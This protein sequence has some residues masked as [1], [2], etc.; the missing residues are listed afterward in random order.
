[1]TGPNCIG[2]D[3]CPAGWVAATPDGVFLRPRLYDLL[4][5]LGV[6]AERD[7]VAIDMPIG[8]AAAGKRAC[9][10]EARRLL[11]AARGNSVF[12][13]ATRGAVYAT[14][15]GLALR[16]AHARASRINIDNDAGGVSAQAFNLFG[17]IREVDALL[18]DQPALRT[19][20]HEVH[21]ELAFACWNAD[22]GG[23]LRPMP[24][25][26]KSGLGAYDR[27]QR[28]F[29][30]YSRAHF[31]HFRQKHRVGHAADDD[32][33]DAYA[34]LF[35]AERIAAGI[36][37]SVPEHPPTDEHGLPMRICY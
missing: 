18:A 35:S 28:V 27:L 10:I 6:V 22:T 25:P 32:I 13:T 20:V 16:D 14:T 3:G 21:P 29:T 17:K 12:P 11:G 24:H 36:H 33:A 2:I 5:T 8:L 31:E 4:Q 30:R 1:M 34:A 37:R 15:A 19:S 23:P 7:I 9:D 26:K